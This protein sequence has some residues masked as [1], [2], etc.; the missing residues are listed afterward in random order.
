MSAS[1]PQSLSSGAGTGNENDLLPPLMEVVDNDANVDDDDEDE[2][3]DTFM[4]PIGDL[5]SSL[6]A[7]AAAADDDDDVGEA[8]NEDDDEAPPHPP[9]PPP[10]PV[11][12]EDLD[13]EAS[14]SRYLLILF[15]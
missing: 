4:D 2:H 6:A 15:I 10:P 5:P 3:E 11:L 8:I 12:D 14:L 13:N 7:V 1:A 9:P